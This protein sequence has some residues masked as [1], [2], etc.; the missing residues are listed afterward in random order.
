MT[1]FFLFVFCVYLKILQI[2][3]QLLPDLRA[4]S[5]QNKYGGGRAGGGLKNKTTKCAEMFNSAHKALLW[6]SL[7]G[8]FGCSIGLF[9]DERHAHSWVI[10]PRCQVPLP[11][12]TRKELWESSA[13]SIKMDIHVGVRWSTVLIAAPWDWF[14]ARFQR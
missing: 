1:F 5:D 12:A 3:Y 11:S 14:N 7:I 10:R 6:P 4:E 13:P 8:T 9:E 2:N